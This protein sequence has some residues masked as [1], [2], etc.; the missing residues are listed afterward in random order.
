M[1]INVMEVSNVSK[2]AKVA[3]VALKK[4]F[5]VKGMLLQLQL[6]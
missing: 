1:L 3:N 5:E 2:V 6:T 4:L